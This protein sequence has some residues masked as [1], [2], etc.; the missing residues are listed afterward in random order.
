M[1]SL[2]FLPAR[3]AGLPLT[4]H[5]PDACWDGGGTVSSATPFI[6]RGRAT[7]RH[8]IPWAWCLPEKQSLKF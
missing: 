2:Q 5:T 8:R 4:H 7:K 6:G 1:G 3:V